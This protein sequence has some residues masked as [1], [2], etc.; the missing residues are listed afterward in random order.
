MQWAGSV[1]LCYV[2]EIAADMFLRGTQGINGLSAE[3]GRVRMHHSEQIIR[4]TITPVLLGCTRR[5]KRTESTRFLS[6]LGVC[7]LHLIHKT[8]TSR[9][10]SDLFSSWVGEWTLS[11]SVLTI[12]YFKSNK[13]VGH[14]KEWG[15]KY[16]QKYKNPEKSWK[17]YFPL[18]C[19]HEHLITKLSFTE[20]NPSTVWTYSSTWQHFRAQIERLDGQNR[21]TA[22]EL[23]RFHLLLIHYQS[24]TASWSNSPCNIL[25]FSS[26]L[27]MN[28]HWSKIFQTFKIF[29]GK[30]AP[31]VGKKLDQIWL[32]YVSIFKTLSKS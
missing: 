6:V 10:Q 7:L 23:G 16:I 19:M 20:I 11:S 32:K 9:E 28:W 29:H 13:G 24:S 27:K 25:A 17:P 30:I 22:L 4:L 1:T 31:S 5:V 14:D 12:G 8:C 2:L 3:K 18:V 21:G 26:G 15:I